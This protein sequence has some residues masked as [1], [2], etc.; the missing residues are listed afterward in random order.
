LYSPETLSDDLASRA[1]VVDAWDGT[2]GDGVRLSDH[3]G[4][5]V[6]IA[7]GSER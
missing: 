2:D 7:E 4:L 6:E 5:V 3:S 1:H